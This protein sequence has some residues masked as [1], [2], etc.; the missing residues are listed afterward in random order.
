MRSR[1]KLIDVG[2]LV[3][4]LGLGTAFMAHGLPKLLG[5]TEMWER[6][7]G[8][9]GN[10]GISFAPAMWGF[11][12]ALAEAGGGALLLLGLFTRPAA[13]AMAFTMLVAAL[14][15]IGRGDGFREW[16][17]AAEALIVFASIVLLGA[18]RL[19]L[20]RRLFGR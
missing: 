19:S 14:F 4:R 1:E 16:S 20:D 15:H 5:G 12:A 9:M 11:M 17:H 18:G 3:L 10:L 2:L 6:V 13:A 8:A 7:G